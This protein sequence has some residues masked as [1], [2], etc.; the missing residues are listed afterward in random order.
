M[1]SYNSEFK[2]ILLKLSN[3]MKNKGDT[4]RANAYKKAYN[5]INS[6]NTPINDFSELK[7]KPNIGNSILSKL[8]EYQIKGSLDIIDNENNSPML[9]FTEIY[10]VGPKKAKE[11]IEKNKITT[12]DGLKQNMHLLNDVQKKGIK[13]YD[14]ILKR[15]PRD[16]IEQYEQQFNIIFNNLNTYNKNN[17]KFEIVGSYRRKNNTSGDI[18]VIITAD[19]NIKQVY[20]DC[21]NSLIS[22]NIIVETLSYGDIKG[23]FISKLDNTK[24]ARRLDFMC[25]NKIEYPFSLLYFTG[26]GN[27]NTEMRKHALTLGYTLNEHGIRKYMKNT[28]PTELDYDIET[29]SDIFDFLNLEYKKPEKRLSGDS[30]ISKQKGGNKNKY[31]KLYEFKQNGIGYLKLLKKKEIEQMYRN[32]L[33]TYYNEEPVISDSLFDILK[34]YIENIYPKSGVLKIIG[35]PIEFE[36]EKVKLPYFMGSMN[37]IKH[38]TNALNKW[39]T[40]FKGSYILSAKLDGI[41]ALYVIKNGIAKLYTRGDGEFG[42]DITYLIPYIN[43]FNNKKYE[44]TVIRGELIMKKNIFEKKYSNSA[45]NARNLVAGIVNSK[46]LATEEKFKDIDFVA[47]EV[48]RPILKPNKQF[49]L[50]TE[51]KDTTKKLNIVKNIYLDDNSKLTNDEISKILQNWRNTYKYEIDGVIITQD[52]LYKNRKKGNPDHS[53]AFKMILTE[54]TMEATVLDVIW[55]PSKDGYLKPRIKITPVNIGGA[56]IEYATAF[57][58]KY[59]V[60]NNIGPGT[61]ISLIRS[62]DVI[63]HINKV[64]QMSDNPKMPDINYNWTDSNVD[65]IMSNK[66]DN[67]I[68]KEKNITGFFTGLNTVGLSKGT[69]NILINSGYDS[70]KSILNIKKDE[71][72][73]LDGF[74]ERRSMKIYEA[75]QDAINNADIIDILSSANIFE[76]GFGKR[77]IKLLFN[78]YPNILNKTIDGKKMKP[79]EL[80]M[81]ITQIDAF[82]RKTASSFVKNIDKAKK[83]INDIGLMYKYDEFIENNYS[84]DDNSEESISNKLDNVRVVITGFRSKELEQLIENNGGNIGT[85][86]SRKVN[87]LI[88]KDLDENT[89]KANKAKK[90][91]IPLILEKDFIENF[92]LDN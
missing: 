11:L 27:F 19:K 91:G 26:S 69:V 13:Y 77:K 66:E 53:V 76:R 34:E 79:V 65:I 49:D 47:Y 71:L 89:S 29:E 57:N 92:E 73:K 5:T 70:V 40:K 2:D 75:I 52:K 23:L 45:S 87:Y 44:N 22:S 4:F 1:S 64:L 25:T 48:I 59:V 33:H 24:P 80:I 54:Q 37:K 90:L 85:S 39:K 21:I 15:I 88:V 82:G 18:D 60:D 32:A 61:I 55:T 10:G 12:I 3:I 67:D 16:E 72:L 41:S 42:Q 78:K 63:P 38:E 14:D 58:A 51:I 30:L 74:K 56:K 17:G 28:K 83:F 86:I 50:M 68:V 84:S 36:K 20:H 62:G 31:E 6:L 9:A 81:F 8:K 7:G 46:K 35:A 43:I